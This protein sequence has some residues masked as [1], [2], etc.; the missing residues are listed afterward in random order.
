MD[1]WTEHGS[2]VVIHFLVVSV[3]VFSCLFLDLDACIC[4]RGLWLMVC[5]VDFIQFISFHFI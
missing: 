5:E 1:G 4:L 2:H 3:T